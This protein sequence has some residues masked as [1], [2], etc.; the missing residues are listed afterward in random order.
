[1]RDELG[2]RVGDIRDVWE[3]VCISKWMIRVMWVCE[4]GEFVRM[5]M[6]VKIRGM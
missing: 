1:M 6:G 5:G 4:W 3:S 2:S